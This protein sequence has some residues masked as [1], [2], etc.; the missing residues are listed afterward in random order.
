MSKNQDIFKNIESYIFNVLEFKIFL[1]LIFLFKVK[2]F[3]IN[4]AKKPKESE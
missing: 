3:K 1:W 2:I 4:D